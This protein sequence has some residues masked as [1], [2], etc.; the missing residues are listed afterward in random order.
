MFRVRYLLY[1]QGLPLLIVV[2]TFAVET[3]KQ[4]GENNDIGFPNVGIYTCFL[5]NLLREPSLPYVMTS[6]FVYFQIIVLILLIINIVLFCLA[7]TR[8]NET[9]RDKIRIL[10]AQEK[11]PSDL[12]INIQEFKMC[13]YFLFLSGGGRFK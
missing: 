12:S 13:L 10:K 11:Q 6:H 5:G 3:Q 7:F 8:I 4:Y 9:F 1:A 2:I